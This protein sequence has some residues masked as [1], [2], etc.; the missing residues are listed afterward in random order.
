MLEDVK[1]LEKGKT[2]LK[3]EGKNMELLGLW[4]GGVKS[5]GR[6][7]GEAE[8]MMVCQALCSLTVHAPLPSSVCITSAKT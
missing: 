3:L 6:K 1:I 5:K 2:T 4:E 8:Q 7:K